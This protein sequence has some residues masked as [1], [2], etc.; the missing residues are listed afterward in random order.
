M[1]NLE[2]S[3]QISETA[4]FVTTFVTLFFNGLTNIPSSQIIYLTLGY[5]INIKDFNFYIAILLGTLGNVLGNLVLYF[6]ILRNSDFLNSKLYKIL[7]PNTEILNKYKDYFKNKYWGWLI[8]GKMTPSLKVLVPIICG[9]SEIPLKRT[10]VIFTV[11]SLVWASAVTYLGYYFGKQADLLEF[12]ALVFAV[13]LFV[14]LIT[15]F[16]IKFSENK[17]NA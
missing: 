10:L 8:L 13:Y 9:L 5:I 6:L 16:K 4:I 1:F 3:E 11:G 14:G 15:Y 12:Y 2:L 17:N 7:G